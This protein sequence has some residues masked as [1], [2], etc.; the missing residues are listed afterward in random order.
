MPVPD[1]AARIFDS[2]LNRSNPLEE[3]AQQHAKGFIALQIARHERDLKDVEIEELVLLNQIDREKTI[4]ERTTDTD[5]RED[6][7]HSIAMLYCE[8]EVLRCKQ[9]RIKHKIE[10]AKIELSAQTTA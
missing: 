8:I 1:N 7:S 2:F 4:W 10:K 6:I 9:P 5:F 3:Y